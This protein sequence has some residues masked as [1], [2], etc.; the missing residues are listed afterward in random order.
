VY[1]RD[2]ANWFLFLR[3]RPETPTDARVAWTGTNDST[4]LNPGLTVRL[5]AMTWTN[6]HP[7][8]EIAA[9]DVTSKVTASDLFLVA[10]T[11]ERDEPIRHRE[12]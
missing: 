1:G 12:R 4:D 7:D 8:R 5:F 2:V 9:I 11:L 10:V 3:A 6:P